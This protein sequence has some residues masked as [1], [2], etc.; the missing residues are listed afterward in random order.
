MTRSKTASDKRKDMI[1]PF[2]LWIPAYL[3]RRNISHLMQTGVIP[4]SMKISVK[5][6]AEA[7]QDLEDAMKQ[8]QK[9]KRE[10]TAHSRS[11]LARRLD[12]LRDEL[13]LQAKI[14]RKVARQGMMDVDFDAEDDVEETEKHFG[15]NNDADED[16][17]DEE[18]KS[19]MQF[20]D[21]LADN[22]LEPYNFSLIEAVRNGEVFV[23]NTEDPSRENKVAVDTADTAADDGLTG[24]ATVQS[25]AAI[26]SPKRRRIPLTEQPEH[27]SSRQRVQWHMARGN[28]LSS[29]QRQRI[30]QLRQRRIHLPA[31][32]SRTL[33]PLWRKGKRLIDRKLVIYVFT[34]TVISQNYC[35]GLD[36]HRFVMIIVC[37]DVLDEREHGRRPSLVEYESSSNKDV[38]LAAIH[39]VQLPRL[40]NSEDPNGVRRLVKDRRHAKRQEMKRQGILL[41]PLV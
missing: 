6:L 34:C 32:T 1:L 19:L 16:G 33:F 39:S 2:Y 40:Q 22:D 20:D 21:P 7:Q 29:P 13:L 28:H 25:S 18:E 41:P 4:D 36:S 11:K 10:K 26:T 3:R 38:V 5:F 27:M 8:E 15:E 30:L 23:R 24:A 12:S 37:D 17:S 9:L 31:S 14:R 35:F